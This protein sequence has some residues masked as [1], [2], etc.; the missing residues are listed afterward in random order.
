[1]QAGFEKSL[2]LARQLRRNRRTTLMNLSSSLPGHNRSAKMRRLPGKQNAPPVSLQRAYSTSTQTVNTAYGQSVRCI[3]FKDTGSRIHTPE[4]QHA[5][6]ST[7]DC[8][9]RLREMAEGIIWPTLSM[10]GRRL[11]SPRRKSGKSNSAFALSSSRRW[12]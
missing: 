1:M 11:A 10:A 5:T 12:L 7:T 9:K 6:E 2:S 3:W 8:I 4:Q